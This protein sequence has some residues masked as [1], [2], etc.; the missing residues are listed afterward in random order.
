[1]SDSDVGIYQI[2]WSD[3]QDKDSED[4]FY[5]TQ[6]ALNVTGVRA[7]VFFESDF[8]VSYNLGFVTVAAYILLI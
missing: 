3:D 8:G 1:M 7:L 4:G 5:K 2:Y 6:L